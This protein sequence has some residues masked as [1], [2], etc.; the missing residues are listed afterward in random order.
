M[1][2][3]TWHI[4]L[5]IIMILLLVQ[6]AVAASRTFRIQ[7]TDFVKITA[8]AIDLDQDKVVYYYTPPLDDQGEWQTN[9]NDAGEYNITITASDGID[10]TTQQVSLIVTNKNQP[11]VVTEN[12]LSIKEKQTIALRDFVQD[13]DQDALEFTFSPPFDREGEWTPDY[14][15]A[16]EIVTT[17]TVSDGEYDVQGRIGV[18]ILNTNQ[19]PEIKEIFSSKATVDAK[20][21]ETFRFFIDV[22]DNDGQPVTYLWQ[23]DKNNLTNEDSGKYFFDFTSAGEHTLEVR[24]SD[25]ESV[26]VEQWKI[27][28]DNTNRKP[29]ITHVPIVVS[30]GEK[31]EL[32]LPKTDIDGETLIYSYETPFNELGGWQ[33]DFNDAGEYSIKVTATDGDLDDTARIQITVLDVDRAPALLQLP[34]QITV[35]EGEQLLWEINAEDPDG[36]KVS[37]TVINAP[38][39]AILNSKNEFL[40][41][42]DYSTIQRSYGF[43]SNLLN[44]LGLE[45]F[46]LKKR[47]IPIVVEA[48]G[49]AECQTEEINIILLN[50]N[51]APVM[52][53]ID[54]VEINETESI[55]INPVA[56]DPDGDIVR[57]TFSNPLSRRGG[58]WTTNYND[59]GTY[60]TT[61]T[62]TDGQLATTQDVTIQVNRRNQPP[63][64]K[65]NHNSVKVDEGEEFTLKLTATDPDEDLLNVSINNLPPGASF[66]DNVFV[67]TP[68]SQTVVDNDTETTLWLEFIAE[69]NDFNSVAVTEVKVKNV[70]QAPELID[71]LPNQSITVNMNEPIIF[72]IAARDLD[73]ERLSYDWDFGFGEPSVSGSST[74]ERT[75]TSSGEKT[76][77]VTVSDKEESFEHEW[78]VYVREQIYVPIPTTPAQQDPFSV[79]VYVIEHDGPL[80]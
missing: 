78:Q 4:V 45:H 29:E 14:N 62:A 25:G 56:T 73:K 76:V 42:P 44:K 54:S 18:T 53:F 7:E 35:R 24:V 36:D 58:S 31:V 8:D 3:K 75:F 41:S 40:W 37:L 71:F 47:S 77:K 70:N 26:V 5:S 72:H 55:L 59:E 50:T 28:V 10:Q 67:W 11:P 49:K 57:F 23:L 46:L 80:S 9:F 39:S 60:T 12:K 66:S 74:I 16:G 51:R 65:V 79:K 1:T 20:E 34:E 38:E 52:E 17:F 2:A 68:N 30:E 6:G 69:D 33:T 61:V 32:Q 43:W 22:K 48:C 19:P 15:D 63:K 27:D 64:L 21:G 13:A